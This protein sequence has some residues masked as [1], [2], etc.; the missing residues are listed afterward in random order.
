MNEPIMWAIAYEIKG[1]LHIDPASVRG[2]RR[3]AI[4]DLVNSFEPG[5]KWSHWVNHR[6]N[7]RRVVKVRVSEVKDDG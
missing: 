5:S 2:T 7:G 1:R 4:A 3:D 6:R